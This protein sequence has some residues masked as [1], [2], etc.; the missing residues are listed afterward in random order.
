MYCLPYLF[1]VGIYGILQKLI[2]EKKINIF[3]SIA[4]SKLFN[5]DMIPTIMKHMTKEEREEG[6]KGKRGNFCEKRSNYL[7]AEHDNRSHS[8]GMTRGWLCYR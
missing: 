1:Y 5:L 7:Q 8:K 2:T 6:K 3:S 4:E